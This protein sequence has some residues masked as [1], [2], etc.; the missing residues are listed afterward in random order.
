MRILITRPKD[1]AQHLIARAHACGYTVDHHPMLA[2]EYPPAP[3]T[4]S[5][6]NVQA[7]AFTSSAAV[8]GLAHQGLISTA[9]PLPAFAVGEG[10]AR[11]LR[12]YGFTHIMP[13]K[14]C[15]SSLSL[16]KTI[17]GHCHPD[18]GSIVHISGA[19]G[20]DVVRQ[21]LQRQGFDVQKY[22]V[23][24]M[25]QQHV[26]PVALRRKLMDGVMEAAL[27]YSPR[28]AHAFC[29][30]MKKFAMENHLRTMKAYAL[31]SAVAKPLHDIPF[32]R[33]MIARHPT[34][35]AI[36]DLLKKDALAKD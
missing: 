33:I 4:L 35:R 16:A 30:L 18:Q 21:T 8:R 22:I 3:A 31:S 20:E 7:L 28:T 19:H 11:T 15:V 13:S 29:A 26:L 14:Y 10:T 9:R 24:K 17:A 32:Q 36:L 27:F 5:L 2:V 34:S 6:S 1:A 25:R 12:D 23:Y